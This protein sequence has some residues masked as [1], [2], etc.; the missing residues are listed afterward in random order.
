MSSRD[1]FI[2]L[3]EKRMT[4]VLK[5]MQLIGNLSN[6]RNY[7]YSDDDY[8]KIILA[9]EGAVRTVKKKFEENSSEEKIEFKL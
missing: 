2:E 3:A 9:L 5:D 1:K 7:K 4:K 6:K 8:K